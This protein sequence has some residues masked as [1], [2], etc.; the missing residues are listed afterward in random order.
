[1]T[2]LSIGKNILNGV[3]KKIN[4]I[5]HNPYKKLG[6]DWLKVRL[7]KNMPDNALNTVSIFGHDFYCFGKRELLHGLKEIF[8]ED[9]YQIQ[10]PENARIIDCGAHIGMSIIYF[11]QICP[12]AHIIAFEPDD[13]NYRLLEQNV[14][15]F[16]LEN[17]TLK[18]EAV[19]IE[20]T[21]ISFSNEGTMSSKIEKTGSE[22][23]SSKVKAARLKDYLGNGIDLIKIDIEG[24]EYEVLKDISGSLASVKNMFLEYHGTFSQ[25]K[26]LIHILQLLAENQFVFYIKEANPTYLTPFYRTAK[27]GPY[28]VQLN[29]FAFRE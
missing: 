8:L 23:A 17:V 19:W 28:D 20:N 12:T 22:N 10:L 9:I 29:I 2:Y 18:K 1:M 13:K 6:M 24:A 25:N 14:R 21:E 4:K 15:S 27:D 11:K 5:N 3:F 16:Q 26:E 7:I